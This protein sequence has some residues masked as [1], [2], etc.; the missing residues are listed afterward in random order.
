VLK[1]SEQTKGDVWDRMH[2][3]MATVKTKKALAWARL[4]L[5]EMAIYA[6][7]IV[8]ADAALTALWNTYKDIPPT[9]GQFH[10]AAAAFGKYMELADRATTLPAEISPNWRKERT[11]QCLELLYEAIKRNENIVIK[12]DDFKLLRENQEFIDILNYIEQKRK[13]PDNPIRKDEG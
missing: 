13:K 1:A 9:W 12:L 4:Q 7:N 6:K 10:L 5:A 8:Q 11:K 2:A 3:L